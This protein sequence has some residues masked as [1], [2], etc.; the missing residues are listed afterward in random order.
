MAAAAP[1]PLHDTGDRWLSH[2]AQAHPGLLTDLSRHLPRALRDGATTIAP[3]AVDRLG[4]RLRVE[5]PREDHDVR[6]G[7]ER[8]VTCVHS[9]GQ[10]VRALA[11]VCPRAAGA[12]ASPDGGDTG[13]DGGAGIRPRAPRPGSAAAG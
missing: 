4:L 5:S 10:E 9:L 1:D 11:G 13:R 2:L 12:G 6:L 3:L 8:P 7:F